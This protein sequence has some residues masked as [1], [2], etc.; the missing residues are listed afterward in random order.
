LSVTGDPA[1]RGFAPGLALKLFVDGKPSQ[2]VSALYT[3]SGQGTNYNFFANELSNYV[4]PEI[5]ETLGTTALFS[6]VTTKPTLLV[7]SDM[8]KVNPNGTAVSTAKAPTQ[9]YFVPRAEVKTKF[10]STAH[11]FRYDLTKLNIGTKV[12]DVYATSAEIKTS[13]ITS[14][15]QSYANQR[16][17]GAQKIGEIELTSPMIV[18]AF[19]DSG[20]F[21]KHQRYEDR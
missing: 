20:V 4:S 9:I 13:L 10:A 19:G 14:I 5:N 7:M 17:S 6:A 1:D 18:S 12:Y 8:A 21:F 15:N 11:D 2:N 3:L 16:R